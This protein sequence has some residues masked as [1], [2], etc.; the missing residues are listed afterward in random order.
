ML[1]RHKSI[2]LAS[3]A[4]FVW[5]IAAAAQDGGFMLEEGEAR[6]PVKITTTTVEA[7]GSYVTDDSYKF[8]EYT[9]L[10]ED[11]SYF[12]GNIE[13]YLRPSYD[14]EEGDTGYFEL[15]GYNLGWDSRSLEMET[16]KQGRYALFF[17]YDQI[18]HYRFNDGQTPF[19]G[20]GSTELALPPGWVSSDDSALLTELDASLRGLDVKTERE[21]IGAGFS[22]DLTPRWQLSTEFRTEEKTGIETIAGIF[23]SNGGN[24][25]SSILP[26]P[27]DYTT[28]AATM[29]LGYGSDRLQA[30]LS[31]DLSVFDNDKDFLTWENPWDAVGGFAPWDPS[32][33]FDLGGQGRIALEPDNSAHQLS[34]SG[35]YMVSPQTRLTGNVSV[36]RLIQDD[37]F[38]PY[39]INESLLVPEDLPRDSLD[40]EVNKIHANVG[41]KTNLTQNTDFRAEYTFD[42][43]D[44]NTPIDTYLVVPNDSVSQGA[45][46]SSLA[47]VNRPYSKRTHNAEAEIGYDLT[48]DTKLGVGYEYE[49]VHRDLQEVN[50]TDEQ[51]GR[52]KLRSRL[53]DSV[54]GRL[55]YA[56]SRRTGS[57]YDTTLPFLVSHSPEFL[58]GETL[59]DDAYEQNAFLRKYYM[60]DRN[61]HLVKGALVTIPSD[62]LT[63]S[64]LG[65]FTLSDYDD[66]EIG[67]KKSHYASGT[68]DGAY[69]PTDSV[70]LSGFFTYE[71]IQFE[72]TGFE[73]VG[74]DQVIG[75]E[76]LTPADRLWDETTR[77]DV[78]TAGVEVAFSA[79]DTLD[80]VLDYTY[81]RA[82]TD[83]DIKTQLAGVEQLPDLETTLNSIGLRA[84]Y[85][86]ADD[87]TLR[88]GYRFEKYDVED[89]ALDSVDEIIA[90]AAFGLGNKSPDYDVHVI[91]VSAVRKF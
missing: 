43:R 77:D 10:A 66:T 61:Q 32:Q 25:R 13:S 18:P 86:V 38:L 52:V 89:F 57:T 22:V 21:R 44:N 91:G 85:K 16:G 78:M 70:T 26:K 20:A 68:V 90:P 39:T 45:I 50:D 6:E 8:G 27:I 84:D 53:T 4:L 28:H 75:G 80:L 30:Q 72:Q 7:G 36:A 33:D 14:N 62:N 81:A 19:I 83:F 9:G 15:R 31:Y 1:Y 35:G 87:L 65:S 29:S 67:L 63:L 2:L 88:F 17:E 58:A 51:T 41:L 49:R 3:V 47:R 73:T 76:T 69:M 79:T 42:D 46:D 55:E 64:I 54:T 40:G 60:A 24:M 74:G 11:G 12:I 5:P 82:V 71:Q 56:Y 34:L 48:A 23:G 37:D 59:P